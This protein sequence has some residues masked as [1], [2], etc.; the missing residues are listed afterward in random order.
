[1]PED[2]GTSL[3][4]GVI[5]DKYN[6]YILTNNHVVS[7]ADEISVILFDERE[8]IAELVG[9]DKLSDL[10]LLK[11]LYVCQKHKYTIDTL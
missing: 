11:M 3:G 9:S 1:M 2:F 5:I 7:K 4:S 8:F 6:G 10:A